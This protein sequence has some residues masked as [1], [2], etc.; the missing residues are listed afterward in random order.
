MQRQCCLK[1]WA[2]GQT[3]IIC[4]AVLTFSDADLTRARHLA[5]Q[6]AI[7]LWAEFGACK[8]RCCCICTC[9][10]LAAGSNTLAVRTPDRMHAAHDTQRCL[11]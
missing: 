9:T 10:G 2:L 3:Q 1:G 7:A 11:S 8:L 5:R 4:P 6:L